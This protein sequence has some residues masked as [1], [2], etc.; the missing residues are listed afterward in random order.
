MKYVIPVCLAFL[1]CIAIRPTERIEFHATDAYPEGVAYD[2]I[3]NSFYVSSQRSGTVGRVNRSGQY[4]VLHADSTLKSSYGMKMHPDGKRLFV[5]IGDANNSKFT[6]P[7]TR[8]KMAR[9]ISI[10]VTTGKKITDL[11]LS[12]LI[13]GKHFVN[14]LAFDDKGNI[15][16]TDSY[17]HAVYKVDQ[18]GKASVFARHP[19]FETEGV[20]LNG[21]VY[22]SGGFLLVN[23][24]A[25]GR[26]YKID[27]ADP[28][29]VD[30]V[31]IEQYFLGADG[32]LLN[33]MNTLTIV[34]NGGNNKIFKIRT[35]NGWK[36]A[37][38]VATTLA[39]DRFTYPTTAASD[40]RDIWVLNAKTNELQD[41][42][43][44]PAKLFSIQKAVF[45]PV[46]KTR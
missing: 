44:L 19:V 25:T 34:V 42:N 35:D 27:I 38:L 14:D 33:D 29:K 15:Y 8:K 39:A 40:G 45:K 12:G 46:P 31:D 7:D 2:V 43:A 24:N 26:L 32:L 23:I 37:Y 1:S 22:H 6:S 13:A 36:S 4:S 3:N 21:I 20:G 30:R 9:L 41:S 28:A 16:I 11:D 10:D 18:A 17:A 5:C